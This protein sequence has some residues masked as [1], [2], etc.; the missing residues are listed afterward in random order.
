MTTKNKNNPLINKSMVSKKTMGKYFISGILLIIIPISYLVSKSILNQINIKNTTKNIAAYLKETSVNQTINN[1]TNGYNETLTASSLHNYS[2]KTPNYSYIAILE[3]PSISLK[4]GLL[5]P[6]DK[7]NNIAYNV[8]I[9]P[10]SQMPG[11]PNSNLIIA[12]H[13]GTSPVS[14]F[15]K[16]SNLT[17]GSL[18]NIYYQGTKY[19]Y[20]LNNYYEID[21]TGEANITRD[22]TTTTLTLITCKDN[23]DTK[24]VVYIAYLISTETY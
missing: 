6:T 22:K 9:L 10:S 11:I 16:L 15:K 24:Q 23:S 7:Y 12:A 1:L 18:I 5:S 17:T 2:N 4:N 19:I 3:I 8:T 21:K 13:N 20:K 14:Y